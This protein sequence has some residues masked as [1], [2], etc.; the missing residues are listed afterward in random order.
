MTLLKYIFS[1]SNYVLKHRFLVKF[2]NFRIF[3][4]IAIRRPAKEIVLNIT[5]AKVGGSLGRCLEWDTPFYIVKGFACN[6]LL[7]H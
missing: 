3:C 1:R 5:G 6:H 2:V 7:S 4:Q